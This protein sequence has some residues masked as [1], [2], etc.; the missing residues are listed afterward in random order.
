MHKS[1]FKRYLLGSLIFKSALIGGGYATGRE[2]VEF[3]LSSGPA[4]GLAAMLVAAAIF[5]LLLVVVFEISRRYQLYDYRSFLQKLLG[6]AWILYEIAF[7]ALMVLIL[8]VLGAAA[9]EIAA[10]QFGVA[11]AL[12]TITQ[13]ALVAVLVFFGT[14]AVE[15]FFTAWSVVLYAAFAVFFV[16]SALV[17][18]PDILHRWDASRLSAGAFAGGLT[19]AGYNMAVIPTILYCARHFDRTRDAVVSGI[20]AGPIAMIPALLFFFALVA[21]YPEVNE[22]HI[23]IVYMLG[24]L[25]APMFYIVFQIVIFGTLIEAGTALIHGFNERVADM[26]QERGHGL[27]RWVRAVMAVA[28]MLVSMLL[29]NRVGIVDL[30]AKGYGYSIYAFLA[31]IAVPVLTRGLWLIMRKPSP[32]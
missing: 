7:L 1:L 31:L 5:S 6:P 16:W 25:R 9:G 2:L 10:K 23:P 4:T 14:R 21:R 26:A 27:P 22:Q 28:L 11:K 20:L 13:T 12:G 18:G 15:R 32:A 24:Q 29:A 19:Y 30:I 8:S 17:L 3:F